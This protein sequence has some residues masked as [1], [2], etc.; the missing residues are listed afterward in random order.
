MLNTRK[1]RIILRTLALC[2][3]P[4]TIVESQEEP[5]TAKKPEV[6]A[7][8][9]KVIDKLDG[10]P[11]N[12]VDVTVK[13]GD[14]ESESAPGITDSKGIARIKNVPKVSVQIRLM[15]HGYTTLVPKIDLKTAEQ[16]LN[17]EL[18]KLQ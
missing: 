15:A 5:R 17:F 9:I 8:Q 11:I 12:N 10:K 6:I 13:W 14:K 7:L 3:V 4:L 1:K 2:F 16:P 18:E